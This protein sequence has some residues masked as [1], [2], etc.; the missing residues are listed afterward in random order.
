MRELLLTLGTLFLVANAAAD[1]RTLQV[2]SGK[3]YKTPCQAFES[4]RNGDIIEIDAAGKYDG[5]VCTITANNLVIRGV[6]GRPRIDAAGKDAQGKAIWV[7]AGNNT[8][9][10]NIELSGC[11]VEDENGAGIRQEGTNLTVRNCYFHDNE[12]GILSG[13]SADSEM[14]V[15]NSEFARNGH[16]DGYSHNIYIGNVRKFTLR[17]CYFHNARGGHLVKS[18][19]GENYILYNRLTDEAGSSYEVDLPNGGIAYVIGNLIQQS[20]TPDNSSLLAFGEEGPVTNS[21]LYVINNTFVNDYSTGL[22]VQVS[23]AVTRAS[24]IVNNIFAGP[25][26]ICSQ[27]NAIMSGNFSGGD[28][29]FADRSNYDYRLKAGSPC[30]NSGTK[31]DPEVPIL[32]SL[33]PKEQYVHPCRSEPRP[34]AGPIDIG[35]YET[36]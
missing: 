5:D 20:P 24:V 6:N 4:A 19:A 30:L 23:R 34:V 14:L 3:K 31:S 33:M 7:I 15:E 18:R 12:N 25:G 13:K 29:M 35:A 8:T 9:V 22:F 2:G 11:R 28:P 26:Q 36:R 1:A 17:Y 27:R 32:D 21:Q 10:E 16:G